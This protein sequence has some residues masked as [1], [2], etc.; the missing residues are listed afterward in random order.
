MN[1]DQPKSTAATWQGSAS[2]LFRREALDHYVRGQ[3]RDGDV[4][5]LTPA[6]TR[7]TYWLLLAV[8]VTALSAAAVF[9][10]DDYVEGTAVV[11]VEDASAV[12]TIIALF[13]GYVRPQLQPGM[14]LRVTVD[15][16]PYA[17]QS[18]TIDSVADQIIG[19]KEVERRLGSVLADSTTA[20]Q[21]LS[22]RW[23][24]PGLFYRDARSR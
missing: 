3:G 11:L 14:L 8:V 15:G 17:S 21:H 12:P 2:A 19:P 10:L 22:S 4:L 6:W 9:T 16:Y 20:R 1:T 5:R 13:P 18:T 23:P 24:H 7:W